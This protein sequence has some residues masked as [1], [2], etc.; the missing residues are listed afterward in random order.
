MKIAV[1]GGAYQS[2]YRNF[3]S[4]RCVNWFP[5]QAVAVE[6]INPKEKQKIL[7]PTPGL[8]SFV[9][10]TGDRVRG[11]YVQNDKC[12]FVVGNVLYEIIG[13]NVS[14][15]G[16]MTNFSANPTGKVYMALNGNN[17]LGIFGG[18]VAYYWDINA[19]TLNQITDADFPGAE[20]LE[21]MDGYGIVVSN[22]SV[23]FASLNDY[24]SWV[25]VDVFTPTYEADKCLRVMKLKGILWCFGSN[26]IEPYYN[27]GTTPFQRVPQ[28]TV[29]IG[30]YAK[31]TVAKFSKNILFVGESYRGSVA[32]YIITE[33]QQVEP[34][35]PS[36]IGDFFNENY[37]ALKSAYAFTEETRTGNQFYHLVIPDAGK[38]LSFDLINQE[39]HERSSQAP[40]P[41][42]IGNTIHGHWRVSCF[43]IYRGKYLA[44]DY[45]SGNVFELDYDTLTENG[46]PITRIRT[47]GTFSTDQRYLSIHEFALDCG[48]GMSSPSGSNLMVRF[49]ADGGNTYRNERMLSLPSTGNYIQRLKVTKLGTARQWNVELKLTDAVDLSLISATVDGI[50]GSR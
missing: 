39:W 5:Q 29:D 45:Y 42:G 25:G 14:T 8:K 47:V 2:K 20:S 44:G 7:K 15:L 36:T 1:V 9:S 31:E 23:Y 27:D 32:V 16:T 49:S 35:T 3:N 10:G 34:I 24:S 48:Y 4:Q 28:A 18:S 40:F 30:L 21:Y 22:G 41:D 46:T 38:T 26:T 13:D 17:Q 33:N 11:L 43:A 12:F 37:E 6:L 19:A 50:Q